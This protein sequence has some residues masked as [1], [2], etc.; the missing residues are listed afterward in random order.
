MVAYGLWLLTAALGLGLFLVWRSALLQLYI[1]LRL[2]KWAFAAFNNAIVI[3][4]ALVWLALVI[5]S[6][7]L[8]RRAAVQG[9][10]ARRAGSVLLGEGVALALGYALSHLA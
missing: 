10:L 5:A 4:L 2:D 7:S 1:R 8:Y 3:V 6:E 9:R